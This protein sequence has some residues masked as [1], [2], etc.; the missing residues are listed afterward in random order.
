[1][2]TSA[3]IMILACHF[4]G[5]W[6][7]QDRET[8]TLKS[9][10]PLYLLVHIVQVGIALIPLV[11]FADGR[12]LWLPTYLAIHAV[13]DWFTWRLARGWITRFAY[14]EDKRFYDTIAIDQLLHLI[15]LFLLI[16]VVP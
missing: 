16:E 6:Y 13:Q 11:Y 1:M 10:D 4:Y 12:W 5:D 9:S 15:V 8:A 14:W 3:I 2:T 7:L